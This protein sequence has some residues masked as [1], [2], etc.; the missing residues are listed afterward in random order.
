MISSGTLRSVIEYGLAFLYVLAV[1]LNISS[2]HHLSQT[3]TLT[4]MLPDSRTMSVVDVF[5]TRSVSPVSGL[6]STLT[7]LPSSS[8]P[9]AG[10]RSPASASLSSSGIYSRGLHGNGD[11]GKP[12]DSAGNPPEWGQMLRVYRTDGNISCGNPAAMGFI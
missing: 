10:S 11:G 3:A 1:F 9:S 4:A 7:S 12:A 5:L 6:S 8:S 2:F